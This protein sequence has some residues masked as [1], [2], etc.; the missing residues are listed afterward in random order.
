MDINHCVI[1]NVIQFHNSECFISHGI[2][3]LI[4]YT[5]GI[6][7]V[8]LKWILLSLT[9]HIP[10]EAHVRNSQMHVF[11]NGIFYP[12]STCKMT[13][14]QETNISQPRVVFI[15][16]KFSL[17]SYYWAKIYVC[18]CLCV[19]T[20]VCVCVCVCTYLFI[21]AICFTSK[22]LDEFSWIL[23]GTCY[24]IQSQV[25]NSGESSSVGRTGI[26]WKRDEAIK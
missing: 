6:Y 12:V 21:S 17:I 15:A 3:R 25:F 5:C 26:H 24:I 22:W 13:V 14:G 4:N 9:Q 1:C 10:H 20:C 18:A 16:S 8:L 2:D 19:C 11:S 7:F 23:Q